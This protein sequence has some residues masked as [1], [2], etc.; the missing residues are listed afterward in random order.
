MSHSRLYTDLYM[1]FEIFQS[2]LLMVAFPF[3]YAIAVWLIRGCP[4]IQE[5][6]GY[7]RYGKYHIRVI[8]GGRIG[9]YVPIHELNICRA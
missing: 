7:I 2:S 6:A 9:V 4:E 3:I 5:T 8:Y 1:V